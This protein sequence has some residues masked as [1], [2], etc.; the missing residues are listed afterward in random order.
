MLAAQA[1]LEGLTLVTND[2]ALQ[3]LPEVTTI[4]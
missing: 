4:W 2:G 3:Q 1:V